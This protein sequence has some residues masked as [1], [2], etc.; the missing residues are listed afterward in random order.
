MVLALRITF[1]GSTTAET[2][3]ASNFLMAVAEEMEIDSTLAK[4]AIIVAETFKVYTHIKWE[5]TIY[6]IH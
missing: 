4:S 3:S 5:I 2:A 6:L 1:N